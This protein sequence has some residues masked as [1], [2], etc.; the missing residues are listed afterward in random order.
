VKSKSFSLLTVLALTASLNTSSPQAD[1]VELTY[2]PTVVSLA[3]TII[4][5][6]HYGAPNYGET[7]KQDQ[8]VQ[9]PVLKLD[10]PVSVSPGANNTDPMNTTTARNIKKIQITGTMYDDLKTHAGKHA[11]LS[12]TLSAKTNA[13]DYTPVV[14][15][16]SAV[17]Y[18]KK[19][20]ASP[21]PH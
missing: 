13:Q 4:F 15:F 1:P 11:V 10:Q 3:G 21:S 6:P 18:G 5:E 14:L 17:Q 20:P 2:A 16:A 19:K 8:K 12:G 7:P 9:I